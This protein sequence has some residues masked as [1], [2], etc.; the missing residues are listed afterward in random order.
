MSR[1]H[2][3][4]VTLDLAFEHDGGTAVNDPLTK[5]LDHRLNVVG[6]RLSK[7]ACSGLPASPDRSSVPHEV[8]MTT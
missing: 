4:F 6:K 8:A 3:D 7:A 2:I 1:H 5:L